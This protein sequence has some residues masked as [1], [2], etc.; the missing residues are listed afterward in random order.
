M[1]LRIFLIFSLIFCI[2]YLSCFLATLI[3]FYH[4][5]F[6]IFL[7][8]VIT[9]FLIKAF[10]IKLNLK[11]I[12]FNNFLSLT[13]KLLKNHLILVLLLL[14]YSLYIFFYFTPSYLGGRDPGALGEASIQLAEN[15]SLYF[16]PKTLETFN[17]QNSNE[18]AL[19]FP[20]FIIKNDHLKSQFNLGFISYSAFFYT[21]FGVKGFFLANILA[22]LFGLTAVYLITYQITNNKKIS[23]LGITL[24]IFSFPFYYHTRTTY[25]ESIA[26]AFTFLT[27]FNLIVLNQ[28]SKTDLKN[29][30]LILPVLAFFSLILI[31][32]EAVFLTPFIAFIYYLSFKN[33]KIK[34]KKLKTFW[35]LIIILGLL[36]LIYS[37][38]MLPFYEK[39]FKDLIDYKYTQTDLNQETGN[40]QSLLDAFKNQFY[41][42][43]YI[44]KIF[45]IYHLGLMIITGFLGLIF[46]VIRKLKKLVNRFLIKQKIKLTPIIIIFLSIGPYLIFFLKPMISMDHPWLLRRFMFSVI[47]LL[48]IFSIYIIFKLFFKK[49]KATY[50]MTIILFC[51]LVYQLP[52]FFKYGFKKENPALKEELA[53][54]AENFN[55]TDLLLIDK[56]ISPDSWSLIAQPLSYLFNKNAVYIYLPQ[57]IEEIPKNKYDNIYFLTSNKTNPNYKAYLANSYDQKFKLQFQQFDLEHFDKSQDY[58]KQVELPEFKKIEKEVY[59]YEVK[60]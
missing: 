6:I 40:N 54:I 19:N 34:I 38:T 32:I 33:Q 41:K 5:A 14:T 31:R 43:N 39:M 26:F 42:T 48:T 16:Q 11:K 35:L 55:E 4:P 57:D 12:N 10:K 21:L 27:V 1:K 60:F 52:L 25:S 2:F 3:D 15:H 47:P 13:K 44:L 7:T 30:S 29:L 17:N 49:N 28:K 51:L 8:L 9:Y 23:L 18:Q 22:L 58:F 46:F 53:K 37:L 56:S 24:I 59:V 45:S 50:V 36:F 20:G